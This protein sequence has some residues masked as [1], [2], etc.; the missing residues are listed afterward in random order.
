MKRPTDVAKWDGIGPR[1]GKNPRR[2]PHSVTIDRREAEFQNAPVET[3]RAMAVIAG[4]VNGPIG[5]DAFP[6]P[7]TRWYKARLMTRYIGIPLTPGAFE[8]YGF[9]AKWT[10]ERGIEIVPAR[11]VMNDWI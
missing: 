6:V 1:D 10:P 4:G 9:W 7:F 11:E 8:G 5:G 3:M 2:E